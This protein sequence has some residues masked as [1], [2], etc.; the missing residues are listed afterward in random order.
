MATAQYWWWGAANDAVI[1][2]VGAF[3]TPE[4]QINSQNEYNGIDV[5]VGTTITSVTVYIQLG[6]DTAFS[7]YTLGATALKNKANGAVLSSASASAMTF[8]NQ[9]FTIQLPGF[10]IPAGTPPIIQFT[11]A[12]VG[13]YSISVRKLATDMPS[14][15]VWL[16]LNYQDASS[17]PGN[18]IWQ[19][20]NGAGITYNIRPRGL[21][22]LG[23]STG[24]QLIYYSTPP[25]NNSLPNSTGAAGT[26]FAIQMASDSPYPNITRPFNLGIRNTGDT[27]EI[28]AASP[29]LTLNQ[30]T[31]NQP[32]LTPLVTKV[33][34]IDITELRTMLANVRAYYGMPAPTW[35]SGPIT[36]LATSLSQWTT[37][38]TELRTV[39]DSIRTYVNSWP[40]N[41]TGNIDIPAINWIPI[42]LNCPKADVVQQIR[43]A[44]ATL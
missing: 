41:N 2:G 13:G 31:Y 20:P 11:P 8:A 15:F 6:A 4:F 36:A 38:I 42:T 21:V 19:S 27:Q 44:I 30:P 3:L 40:T 24:T 25:V 35:A 43:D 29:N 32:N 16:Y 10:T 12:N 9:L 14:V 5:P 17:P 39:W 18:P 23:S 7:S 22:T 33:K 1:I 28:L 26:K 37:H 34:A